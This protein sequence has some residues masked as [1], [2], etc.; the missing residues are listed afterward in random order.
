[1]FQTHVSTVSSVFFCMWQLLHLDVFKIDQVLH[2]GYVW[3]AGEDMTVLARGLAARA[4]C[5]GTHSQV[6]RC[7]AARSLAARAPSDASALI[8][9]PG[10]S[11]S[12]LLKA[13]SIYHNYGKNF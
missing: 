11:K 4:R 5:W 2:M 10:A 6:R 3:E 12:D 8:E 13:S 9:R 7:L 1:M